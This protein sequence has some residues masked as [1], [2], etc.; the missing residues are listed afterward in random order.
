M[1]LCLF[2]ILTS[3]F[4]F[5]CFFF[6]LDSTKN[7]LNNSKKSELG[8]ESESIDWIMD[9]FAHKKVLKF[10]LNNGEEYNIISYNI[11]SPSIPYIPLNAAKVAQHAKQ[12]LLQKKRLLNQSKHHHHHYRLKY[13]FFSF[14]LCLFF[15][16][17]YSFSL[18]VCEFDKV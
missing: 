5:V 1:C 4:L 13:I 8:I 11:N 18:F 12:R 14:S 9:K 10:F 16:L 17:F 15:L 2:L 7:R 3:F 6:A